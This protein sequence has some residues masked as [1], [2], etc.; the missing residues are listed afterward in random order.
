MHGLPRGQVL[1]DDWRAVELSL[2]AV[3][4]GHVRQCARR[5]LGFC[6]CALRAWKFQRAGR[7]ELYVHSGDVPGRDVCECDG[8]V[9]AVQPRDGVQRGGADRA[10]AVLLECK[11]ARGERECGV[12]GRAGGGCD[13]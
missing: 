11:Y 9:R 8:R 3:P 7:G 4:R 12:G 1:F 6:L 2:L 10:A 5:D 13:V